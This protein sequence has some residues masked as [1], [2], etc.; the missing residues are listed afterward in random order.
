MKIAG[1]PTRDVSK[2]AVRPS[3]CAFCKKRVIWARI[4]PATQ[5]QRGR[6]LVPFPVDE[7][8]PGT[9]NIALTKGLFELDGQTPLAEVVTNGTNYRSHRDHCP[10]MPKKPAP[11]AAGAGGARKSFTSTAPQKKSRGAL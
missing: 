2:R 11:A 3:V 4:K 5:K 6:R 8:E 9:G 1:D 7:C 10:T